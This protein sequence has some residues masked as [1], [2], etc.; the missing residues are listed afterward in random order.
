MAST[1]MFT[2][3]F[4]TA[5]FMR[6]ITASDSLLRFAA[7][8]LSTNVLAVSAMVIVAYAVAIVTYRRGWDLDN[9]VIPIESSLADSIT[10]A[11]LLVA[12]TFIV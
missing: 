2:L 9:F 4:I 7:E 12:L 5:S 10:T 3:F 6:R 1:I 11:S 8:L